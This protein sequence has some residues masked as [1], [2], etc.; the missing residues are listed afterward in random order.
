MP[1]DLA[2]WEIKMAALCFEYFQSLLAYFLPY[3]W[4]VFILLSPFAHKAGIRIVEPFLY[5][6]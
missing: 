5:L 3:H 2:L 1:P 6:Y 4:F